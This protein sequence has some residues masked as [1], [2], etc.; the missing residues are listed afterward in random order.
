M[1]T[2][3]IVG[4]GLIGGSFGLAVR[5][6]GFSGEV[7]GVSEPTYANIAREMG[8]VTSLA[9]LDEICG[10]ADL[11]Y[12]AQPVAGILNTLAQIGPALREHCLLTDS[13]STKRVICDQ[14]VRFVKQAAFLGGH[15]MAGKEKRGI[16]QA[17]AELFRGRTYILT[18]FHEHVVYLQDEFTRLLR[19]MGA[20]PVTLTALEH[21]QT[22]A[23]TSHLPQL[24]STALAGTLSEEYAG[25]IPAVFGPGLL[26]MTRLAVSSSDLWAS[27]I[28]TNYDEITGALQAFEDQLRA[29]KVAVQS[30]GLPS[31]FAHA[32][33][34]A[35]ALRNS[36]NR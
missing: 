10:R 21:D 27:I 16:E 29:L 12:L 36:L 2:I 30:R 32:S 33:T 26:D 18:P 17:E 13:G 9:S 11:I 7:L 23:F 20:I 35:H 3:G 34:F 15:P 24:L 28:E 5:K 1:E 14:A 4:L 25:D 31:A 6:A 22:V 19:E 8:A